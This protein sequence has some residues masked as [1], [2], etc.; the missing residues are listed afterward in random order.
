MDYTIKFNKSY[1]FE[2]LDYKEIDLSN[3][4]NLTTQDLASIDKIYTSKGQ[5]D[6]LKEM[7]VSY[8]CILAAQVASKPVE[9]FENLPARE[10]IKL[11]TVVAN[12]L[13]D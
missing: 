3:L 13:L 10:G 11:K 9:F 8:A 6:P 1:N 12:F 4:E 2:G 7:S 5:A